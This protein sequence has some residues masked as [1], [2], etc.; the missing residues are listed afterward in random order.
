M[1]SSGLRRCGMWDFRTHGLYWEQWGRHF[2]QSWSASGVCCLFPSKLVVESDPRNA[3][4][5]VYLAAKPLWRFTFY[6]NEVNALSSS[7]SVEFIHVRQTAS[8]LY[9]SFSLLSSSWV[10]FCCFPFV[11][12]IMPLYLSFPLPFLVECFCCLFLLPFNESSC[13]Q[14]KNLNIMPSIKNQVL[15]KCPRKKINRSNKKKKFYL[16]KIMHESHLVVTGTCISEFKEAIQP[17][18]DSRT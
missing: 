16:A 17:K 6:F 5:W 8:W 14:L 7:I 18:A 12:G 3:I 15:D 1:S 2:R 11:V 9:C 13:Y 4:S 10:G